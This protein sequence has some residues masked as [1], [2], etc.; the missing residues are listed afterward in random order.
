MYRDYREI[1]PEIF[2]LNKA[3][4]VSKQLFKLTCIHHC[5]SQATLWYG[6]TQRNKWSTFQRL[7]VT[8]ADKLVQ[9]W[10]RTRI[11]TF[12]KIL[13]IGKSILREILTNKCSIFHQQSTI[14]SSILPSLGSR[15]QNP[16]GTVDFPRIARFS[17]KI[18]QF[19]FFAK[20][21]DNISY[22]QTLEPRTRLDR[23]CTSSDRICTSDTSRNKVFHC[24]HISFGLRTTLRSCHG[25]PKISERKLLRLKSRL[26]IVYM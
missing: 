13:I 21:S 22:P 9:K 2:L 8:P 24:S 15:S 11:E 12:P 4:N 3:T 16:R 10:H 19:S 23:I 26:T 18:A 6:R 5:N 25:W 17:E 20:L 14:M 7:A 1:L